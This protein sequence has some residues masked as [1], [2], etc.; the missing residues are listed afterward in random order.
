MEVKYIWFLN[1]NNFMELGGAF[2]TMGMRKALFE[3]KYIGKDIEARLE[4]FTDGNTKNVNVNLYGTKAESLYFVFER[5]LAERGIDS[6]RI[7]PHEHR[8]MN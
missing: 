1:L 8:Y 4:V 3:N 5:Y 2:K 7:I 6:K